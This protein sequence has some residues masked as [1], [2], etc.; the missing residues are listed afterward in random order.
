MRQITLRVPD[1]LHELVTSAAEAQHQSVNTF[2]VNAL[3]GQV[4][5]KSFSEWRQHIEQSHR[6]SGFAGMSSS[7]LERLRTMT[8]D[9][10]E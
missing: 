2:A 7:A 6:A 1:E 5:A 3:L 10:A 4:T 9:E 8:G